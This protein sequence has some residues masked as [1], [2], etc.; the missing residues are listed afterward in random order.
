MPG[1]AEGDALDV[2]VPEMCEDRRAVAAEPAEPQ[3]G[4]WHEGGLVTAAP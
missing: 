3:V 4:E 1:H 2:A